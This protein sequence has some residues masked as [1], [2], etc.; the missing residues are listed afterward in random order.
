MPLS[1]S[2]RLY[3]EHQAKMQQQ[4]LDYENMHTRSTIVRGVHGKES[5]IDESMYHEDMKKVSFEN[6]ATIQHHAAGEFLPIKPEN[7]HARKQLA[8]ELEQATLPYLND[9]ALQLRE[10]LRNMRNR[11]KFEN[12]TRATKAKL[13]KNAPNQNSDVKR[14]GSNYSASDDMDTSDD[15]P[16]NLANAKRKRDNETLFVENMRGQ[17]K[18]GRTEASKKRSLTEP[19][20]PSSKRQKMPVP[21][22]KRLRGPE[23]R[24]QGSRRKQPKTS[25]TREMFGLRQGRYEPQASLQTTNSLKRKAQDFYREGMDQRKK[26]AIDRSERRITNMKRGMNA[27]LIQYL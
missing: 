20:A 26:R 4:Q 14:I 11:V 16:P 23:V 2:Q 25:D 22:K 13:L 12:E 21:S 6:Q 27:G 8:A 1:K 5:K 17:R 9:F 19:S 7:P 24:R 10:G 3:Y 15:V 18:K